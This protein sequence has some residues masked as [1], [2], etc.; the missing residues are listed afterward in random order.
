[1]PRLSRRRIGARNL[2]GPSAAATHVQRAASYPDDWCCIAESRELRRRVAARAPVLLMLASG[3][4]DKDHDD[5]LNG[6]VLAKERAT[7]KGCGEGPHL[8]MRAYGRNDVT[9]HWLPGTHALGV[10]A[11]LYLCQVKPTVGTIEV[12]P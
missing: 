1:M 4:D 11:T 3:C 2:P 6:A 8:A 9:M 5:D 7:A 10:S 12:L